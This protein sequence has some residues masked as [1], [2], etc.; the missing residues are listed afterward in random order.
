MNVQPVAP[1]P[2]GLWYRPGEQV[3]V[4]RGDCWVLLGS[5]VP[6]AL[7]AAA[8]QTLS[9]PTNSDSL[10]AAL[11]G[12]TA[13]GTVEGIGPLAFTLLVEQGSRRE[14]F[15]GPEDGSIVVRTRGDVRTV[16]IGDMPDPPTPGMLVV[17]DGIVLTSGLVH[18]LPEEPTAVADGH[19]HGA[20][21]DVGGRI[22]VPA[23]E[24]AVLACGPDTL[25]SPVDD[26]VEIRPRPR[27]GTRPVAAS[28]TSSGPRIEVSTGETFPL[29]RPLVIGRRPQLTRFTDDVV[30]RLVTVPSPQQDVSRTHLEIRRDSTGVLV[31]DLDSTNGTVIRKPTGDS[32]DLDPG[33]GERLEDGD[34]LDLGDG[35]TVRYLAG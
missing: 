10:L 9:A 23:E 2:S 20:A 19:W 24:T 11:A 13:D 21:G 34:L 4:A 30:P 15:T 35:V 33:I 3:L 12:A 27:T 18:V 7:T 14:F 22:P 8:W 5:S 26:E 28:A 16:S 17:H 29:D 6:P 1:A 31:R 32:R 25:E